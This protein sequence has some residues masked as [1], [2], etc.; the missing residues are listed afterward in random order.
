MKNLTEKEIEILVKLLKQA[1]AEDEYGASVHPA[2]VVDG[3]DAL[4]IAK[5]LTEDENFTF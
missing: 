4:E 1:Y 2:E 5:K 3:N